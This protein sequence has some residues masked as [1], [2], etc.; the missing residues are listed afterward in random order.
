MV[1]TL[2]KIIYYGTIILLKS[3]RRSILEEIQLSREAASIRYKEKK[4]ECTPTNVKQMSL[5]EAMR[6]LN[7]DKLS[8][9][10]VEEKYKHL[11]RVNSRSQSGSFYLQSKVYRARE[12]INAV[13]KNRNTALKSDFIN[14]SDK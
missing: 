3:I 12:R 14:V 11:L 7:V 13:L 6:I 9:E 5:E 10:E 2:P 8:A 4:S 1:K